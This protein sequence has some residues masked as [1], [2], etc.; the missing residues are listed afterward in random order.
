MTGNQPTKEQG[1]SRRGSSSTTGTSGRKKTSSKTTSKSGITTGNRV[2]SRGGR[3]STGGV[4]HLLVPGEMLILSS[5][6][7]Q[8]LNVARHQHVDQFPFNERANLYG[9]RSG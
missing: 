2:G 3:R 8:Q 4:A 6:D 5:L 7:E 1:T 9:F